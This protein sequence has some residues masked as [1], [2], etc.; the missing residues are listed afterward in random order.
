MRVRAMGDGS[1]GV[2]R[3]EEREQHWP[4]A[5]NPASIQTPVFADLSGRRRRRMRQAGICVAAALIGCLTVVAVALLGGPRAPFVPW[6]PVTAVHARPATGRT[7]TDANAR[8]QPAPAPV[9]IPSPSPDVFPSPP[10]SPSPAAVTSGG[11]PAATHP[12]G[13]TPPRRHRTHPPR[14]PP[15]RHTPAA[16]APCPPP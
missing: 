15:P 9:L 2:P 5:A 3:Q 1:C 7:G 12:G 8:S 4:S 14:P 11:S 16:D 13:P 6:A 10:R